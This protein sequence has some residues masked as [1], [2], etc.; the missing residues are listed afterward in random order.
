MKAEEI[1][2]FSGF[3]LEKVQ[4]KICSWTQIILQFTGVQREPAD[5][6]QRR[7]QT[8]GGYA[9]IVQPFYYDHG[10]ENKKK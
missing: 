5:F 10:L 6:I 3:L 1:P 7:R 9:N 2:V 8:G 4:I